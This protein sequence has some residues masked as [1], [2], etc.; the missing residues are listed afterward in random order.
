[1][2]G[3]ELGTTQPHSATHNSDTSARSSARS[4]SPSRMTNLRATCRNRKDQLRLTPRATSNR[5]PHPHPEQTA[6]PC[7][8]TLRLSAAAPTLI[9]KPKFSPV[10]PRK[11]K[12]ETGPWGQAEGATELSWSKDP[13]PGTTIPHFS[14][15][16]SWRTKKKG[17]DH[18]VSPLSLSPHLSDR[19]RISQDFW[20]RGRYGLLDKRPSSEKNRCGCRRTAEL[21]KSFL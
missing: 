17:S 10:G 11:G 5:I 4:S 9:S 3:A 20:H 8:A 6:R 14:L 13:R 19:H 18:L 12:E 15:T 21:T 2:S 7:P 1:M 16:P